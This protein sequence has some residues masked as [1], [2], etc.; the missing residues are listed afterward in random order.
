MSSGRRP[1]QLHRSFD[2]ARNFDRL[3]GVIVR[4]APPESAADRRHMHFH[5]IG[6]ETEH[7]GRVALQVVRVLGRRPKFTVVRRDGRGA[8]HRLERRVGGERIQVGRLESLCGCA[9]RRGWF[10]APQHDPGIARGLLQLGAML[11]GI[12][13]HHLALIPIGG[14]GGASFQG[15]PGR[16][17]HNR[18]PVRYRHDGAHPANSAG[19]L[20]VPLLRFCA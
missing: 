1:E 10:L 9:G 8:V 7:F 17:G 18:N 19:G 4:Q 3:E 12:E 20:F 15:R 13:G 16:V 6:R 11:V 5:F 2:R 14:E